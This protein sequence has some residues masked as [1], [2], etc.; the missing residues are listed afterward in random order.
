MGGDPYAS[1]GGS[2]TPLVPSARSE[3]PASSAGVSVQLGR[4]P[5]DGLRSSP[6]SRELKRLLKYERQLEQEL[7]KLDD[8][9]QMLRSL[10]AKAKGR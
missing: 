6:R 2:Q 5:P 1:G 7:R 3:A 8:E 9:L 10:V 4:D